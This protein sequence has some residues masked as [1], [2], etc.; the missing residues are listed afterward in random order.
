[1]K[2]VEKKMVSCSNCKRC[3]SGAYPHGPYAYE[4][5]GS[6]TKDRDNRKWRYLGKAGGES[7]GGGKQG[8]DGLPTITG[9]LDVLPKT[10]DYERMG[11]E[12]RIVENKK[13]LLG[14]M[15]ASFP[16]EHSVR[17]CFAQACAE[18]EDEHAVVSG[19]VANAQAMRYIAEAT[20]SEFAEA[21]ESVLEEHGVSRIDQLPL[22]KEQH[23]VSLARRLYSEE[24]GSIVSTQERSERQYEH[25]RGVL[26]EAGVGDMP[27]KVVQGKS[28]LKRL[29]RHM[30]ADIKKEGEGMTGAEKA[31]IEERIKKEYEPQKQEVRDRIN[32]HREKILEALEAARELREGDGEKPPGPGAADS[33]SHLRGGVR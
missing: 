25:L 6:R 9:K 3:A 31:A 21:A 7:A 28:E 29:Q 22:D 5:S 13:K 12:Q 14:A 19:K 11:Y 33:T 16:A 4:V 8:E 23:L 1:M 27:D 18:Q 10:D 15:P 32:A 2:Y 30:R 24:R 20:R 26:R 17:G